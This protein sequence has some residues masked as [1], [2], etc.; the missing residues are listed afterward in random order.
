MNQNEKKKP[1]GQQE[2]FATMQEIK[3]TALFDNSSD[4]T[5]PAGG[6]SAGAKNV[7]Y[8][9]FPPKKFKRMSDEKAK[10]FDIP[11]SYYIHDFSSKEF[12]E[13]IVSTFKKTGLDVMIDYNHLS[14]GGFFSYPSREEGE[15]A[16]WIT[17]LVDGGEGVGVVAKIEWTKRGEESVKEKAYKYFSPEFSMA[18]LDKDTGETIQTPRLYAVALTNRPFIENQ[19]PV[20]LS[21]LESK[22][23]AQHRNL[24]YLMCDHISGS[25]SGQVSDAGDRKNVVV[26]KEKKEDLKKHAAQKHEKNPHKGNIAMSEKDLDQKII[27]DEEQ[28]AGEEQEEEHAQQQEETIQQQLSDA[29]REI[30]QLRLEKKIA[31]AALLASLEKQK[32]SVINEALRDGRLVPAMMNDIKDYAKSCG[33]DVEKLRKFLSSLPVQTHAEAVGQN[34][35]QQQDG[36]AGTVELS[37]EDRLAMM[38]GLENAAEM[39]R[40]SNWNTIGADGKFRDK[41]NREIKNVILKRD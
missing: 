11:E 15:A 5:V 20:E 27:A 18:F 22:K 29:K 6:G 23:N 2:I 10:E 34:K 25:E 30:E 12:R 8:T 26:V 40:L 14:G 17:D 24:V 38:F 33:S 9:V 37:D 41:Q 32:E 39:N 19:T 7:Y 36:H 4:A 31:D 28:K 16:G 13:G 21:D 1:Q 3:P 35:D